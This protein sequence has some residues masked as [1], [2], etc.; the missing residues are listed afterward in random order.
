MRLGLLQ[1]P[2]VI[3][4]Q[5]AKEVKA[6]EAARKKSQAPTVKTE[7]ETMAD[8]A[9][10]KQERE[11]ARKKI[12]AASTPRIRPLSETKAIEMGAN[13]V[14]EAFI[15][16]VGIGVIVFEQWRQRR[17]ARNQRDDIREDID[18]IKEEFKSIRAEI[19]ALKAHH[20]EPEST[21]LLGLLKGSGAP[22]P[23]EKILGQT[24]EEE[25]KGSLK[26]LRRELKHVEG[27]LE[28]IK[29]RH[30][31]SSSWLGRWSPWKAQD[32]ASNTSERSE[33]QEASPSAANS[34]EPTQEK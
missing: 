24:E 31:Q 11:A 5:I 27:D 10:T 19:E 22:K 16:S 25:M 23:T 26:Q 30:T 7:A 34:S 17:K 2:A 6:A 9:M 21:G 32:T 15:F 13:F 33:I 1:D 12:E 4:R 20:L 29:E 18:D 28:S 8:E 3:D 14:A